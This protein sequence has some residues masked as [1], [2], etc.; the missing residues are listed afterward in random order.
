M[1]EF[2]IWWNVVADDA[3]AY[4]D[5]HFLFVAHP[6][7]EFPDNLKFIPYTIQYPAVW[8]EL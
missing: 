5:Y 1:R 3:K 4:L 6:L 2:C 8:D 7:F